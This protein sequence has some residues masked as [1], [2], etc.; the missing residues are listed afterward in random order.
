MVRFVSAL[1]LA[2]GLL[3]PALLAGCKLHNRPDAPA[4]PVGPDSVELDSAYVFRTWVTDG[5]E[6]GLVWVRFDWGDGDTSSWCGPGQTVGY[7]H[8]WREGGVFAV[9]AQARDDRA[10]WSEWSGPCSVAAVVPAYPYRLVDSVA[11]VGVELL[12]AQVL[13]SGE[14][15]YV[16]DHDGTLWVVRTSD[17]QRVAEI[18]L[19][20]ACSS[21]QLVCS[22]DG[23]Y[24]YATDYQH[25][26]VAVI[27]TADQ[28][29]V[30]SLM[31]EAGGQ[32]TSIAVSPDGARLYVAVED[33]SDFIAS[34]RLPDNVVED[35]ILI[36]GP[37]HYISSL[38]VAPDGSHLFA[39]DLDEG[40]VCSI[41]LSDNTIEWQVPAWVSEAPG[42]TVLHPAGSP[43]YLL[44]SECVS[45]L[46]SG[47]GSLVD[48]IALVPFWGADISPDG[49]FLYCTCSVDDTIGAVAVVRTSDNEV[50][51]FVAIPNG[52]C[53]VAPSTDG[54][55]L[56]AVSDHA[57]Y[58]LSR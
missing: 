3:L 11:L 4:V 41:R 55:R 32:P 36:P 16:A 56:Y 22:P 53:D 1:A 46:E 28:T 35:T 39:S 21:P 54:R 12:D 45:V 43:L 20:G 47:T 24:V 38:H 37:D 52:A 50:A 33:G 26:G 18:R 29:V 30:D 15:V 5:T 13:P 2:A 14:F 23:E 27:R 6:H 17:M 48:T 9:R 10:E 49:S 8:S 40:S 31:V 51:R 25:V 7:S 58:V 34:Y 42:G 19:S 44:K 57:L